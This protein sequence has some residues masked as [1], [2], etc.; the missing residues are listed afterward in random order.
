[1]VQSIHSVSAVLV[2]YYPQPDTLTKVLRSLCPQVGQVELVDN[3]PSNLAESAI[4]EAVSAAAQANV[5]VRSL[6]TNRGIGYAQ[7]LGIRHAQE[8]GCEFVI[9]S[10]Q[11]T[12][13]PS[14]C[15]SVL[16]SAVHRIEEQG[17]KIAAIGPAYVNSHSSDQ[18]PIF[19]GFG[20]GWTSRIQRESG[21]VEVSGV[22]ASGMLIRLSALRQ[23]G[24]MNEELF[25]DWVD[26]E[27][28]WRAIASGHK[29]IGCFD[30]VIDHQLGDDSVR[31]GR[32]SF[33]IRSPIRSYYITRN[34]IFL[35]TRSKSLPITA[36]V[37]I[38][39]KAIKWSILACFLSRPRFSQAV[40]VMRGIYH[41]LAGYLGPIDRLVRANWPSAR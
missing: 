15:V 7:N 29:I 9:L 5:T 3:T 10:D 4:S 6:G 8:S 25:I 16:I 27:W 30:T 20:R 11:D 12:I 1:M 18:R 41:G 31:I 23:I 13:F 22:I 38:G 37:A 35:A 17:A 14:D 28:C 21:C 40:H 19:L 39:Y 33:S 26:F 32:A 34:G 24:L 36:A 2:T